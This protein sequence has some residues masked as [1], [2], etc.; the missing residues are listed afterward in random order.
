M[1][2]ENGKRKKPNILVTGTPGTGKTTMCTALAE[3]TQLRHINVGELVKEK[4]LHDGWDDELDCHVL[5]EDLVCD[6]LEDVME[7]GGNI[8][9][10]HGC[11][12][13]PERWFDC[14]VVLQTDNTVLYDRLSRR[15]YKD[16]KLS[17]NIEC[18]IFQVLLEEAK[19]SYSEEKLIAMKS[20]NIEDI[21]RNVATLTDWV[22]N[23]SLPSQS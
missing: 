15:G 7:E 23:W 18:E 4:N 13:F 3:A 21:S 9:D 19:E 1:V 11:D 6:E 2:Q 16:S 12:F 10:Y 20:D 17:N 14:V 22:R 8:V 5:N